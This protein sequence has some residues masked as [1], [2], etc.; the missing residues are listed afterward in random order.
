LPWSLN[1]V[2]KTLQRVNVFCDFRATQT[3]QLGFVLKYKKRLF[4]C[5]ENLVPIK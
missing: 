2:A 3:R 1:E 5:Q 4:L